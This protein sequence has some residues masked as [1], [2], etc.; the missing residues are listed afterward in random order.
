MQL[1]SLRVFRL[2]SLI[3]VVWRIKAVDPA[4]QKLRCTEW[5]IDFFFRIQCRFREKIAYWFPSTLVKWERLP[6]PH[7]LLMSLCRPMFLEFWLNGLNCFWWAMT[8]RGH[9]PAALNY[10]LLWFH[11]QTFQMCAVCSLVMRHASIL[12]GLFISYLLN[13]KFNFF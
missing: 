9:A 4:V 3:T 6:C 11:F 7:P 12:G 10:Y 13:V 2:S 1:K 5:K 8:W